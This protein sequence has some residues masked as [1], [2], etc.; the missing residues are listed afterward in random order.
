MHTLIP[1]KSPNDGN[2]IREM[3]LMTITNPIKLHKN[4]LFKINQSK[5]II[6]PI[7]SKTRNFCLDKNTFDKQIRENVNIAMK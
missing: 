2:F 6:R 5:P 7:M 4:L 3:K 1:K